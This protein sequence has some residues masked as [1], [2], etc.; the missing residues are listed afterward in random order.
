MNQLTAKAIKINCESN[1]YQRLLKCG[2]DTAALHAGM[3]CLQPGMSVGKHNTKDGE[4]VLI[5][6]EG[7]GEISFVGS[8]SL[9]ME[10]GF[11]IYCPS[12]TEH[13]VRNTG[14]EPLR[15]V[16]VVAKV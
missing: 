9:K 16:F 11:M 7:E 6:L 4:E 13:D 1:D 2:E 12:F 3:V 15:Y 5:I 8:E 10:K 14:S